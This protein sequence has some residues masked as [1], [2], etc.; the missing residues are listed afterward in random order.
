[1]SSDVKGEG[2]IVTDKNW[3]NIKLKS[4]LTSRGFYVDEE[5]NSA[6]FID[7]LIV[8][9]VEVDWKP[10]K[11]AK[12]LNRIQGGKMDKLR[13]TASNVREYRT[14][15]NYQFYL[16]MRQWL[17]DQGVGLDELNLEITEAEPWVNR[18]SRQPFDAP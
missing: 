3:G 10:F 11:K 17:F 6:G 12:P 7:Y 5:L 1:M 15:D 8:S 2:E 9:C 16:G 18:C 4:E 13:E 14:V